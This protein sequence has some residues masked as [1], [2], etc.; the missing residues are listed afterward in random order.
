MFEQTPWSWIRSLRSTQTAEEV[1]EHL[2]RLSQRY[3]PSVYAYLRK[4]GRSPEQAAEITQA[5]FA[6]VIF[7]RGFFQ[8]VSPEVGQVRHVL[9]K[10]I[11]NYNIDWARRQSVPGRDLLSLDDELPNIEKKLSDTSTLARSR[12]SIVDG[13]RERLSKCWNDVNKCISNRI[14]T[15]SGRPGSVDCYTPVCTACKSRRLHRSKT[16]W[17]LHPHR[18]WP[19]RCLRSTRVSKRCCA[20]W[21]AR[22]FPMMTAWWSRSVSTFYRSCGRRNRRR[23]TCPRSGRP[24]VVGCDASFRYDP[25]GRP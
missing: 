4:C 17:D 7:G 15:S 20:K 18:T 23:W 2:E 25:D 14:G 6:D 1:R 19:T 13:H 10:A 11:K 8:R 12:N 5:F 22:P 3:W 9:A 16:N 24:A 21:S